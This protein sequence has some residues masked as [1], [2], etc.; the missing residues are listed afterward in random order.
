MQTIPGIQMRGRAVTTAVNCRCGAVLF[1]LAPGESIRPAGHAVGKA[2]TR[3]GRCHC[4]D[5]YTF[6]VMTTRGPT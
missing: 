1:R 6:P 3:S 4:G 5:D 2:E